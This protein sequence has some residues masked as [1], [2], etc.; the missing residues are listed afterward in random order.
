[1][2]DEWRVIEWSLHYIYIIIIIIIIVI[3]IIIKVTT[4]IVVTLTKNCFGIRDS[5]LKKEI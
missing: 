5:R 3:I 4:R 1:M 2:T